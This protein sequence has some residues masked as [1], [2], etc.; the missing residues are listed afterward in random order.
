VMDRGARRVYY[1]SKAE[2]LVEVN[3]SVHLPLFCYIVEAKEAEY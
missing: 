2:S 1:I 3:L